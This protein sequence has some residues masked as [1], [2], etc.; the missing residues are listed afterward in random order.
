MHS[1]ETWLETY[2]QH[3]GVFAYFFILYFESLGVP[4]PG[5]SGLVVGS[6]LAAAGKLSLPGLLLASFIGSVLGDCTGYAIG[7]F[8]GKNLLLR[9]GYLIKLTPERLEKFQAQ[10]DKKGFYFVATAR[11]IVIARQ[12][13]GIIAGSGGMAFHKFLLANIIGAGAWTL[14]WG[15]GPYLIKTFIK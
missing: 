4:L 1:I 6:L 15:A 13:N 9:Y 2:I 5:E 12:L 3:Y 14:T 8:G 7:H 11:F 10:L